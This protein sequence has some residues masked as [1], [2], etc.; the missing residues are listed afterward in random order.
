MFETPRTNRTLIWTVLG[1]TMVSL[2][3]GL[4]SS[5][6]DPEKGQPG[7]E[8]GLNGYQP[9]SEGRMGIA[10]AALA[11]AAAQEPVVYPVRRAFPFIVCRL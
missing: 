7:N 6:L 2:S 10:S 8:A 3:L 1:I 11:A 9:L 4:L 5:A